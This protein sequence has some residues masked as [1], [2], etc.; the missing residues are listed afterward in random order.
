MQTF[1]I[2]CFVSVCNDGDVRLS[3]G[4]TESEGTVE[5]VSII[6]GGLWHRVDGVHQMQR[7]LADNL[8]IFQKVH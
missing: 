4:L 3:G 2:V 6:F 8:D 5:S 7:S 1:N